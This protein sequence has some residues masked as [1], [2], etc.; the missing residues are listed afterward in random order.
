[1]KKSNQIKKRRTEDVK[2][3]DPDIENKLKY[4][5]GK[6]PK[7]PLDWENFASFE[8]PKELDIE[9]FKI[10]L[11]QWIQDAIILCKS[12][13]NSAKTPQLQVKDN[14]LAK[15]LDLDE[16]AWKK[17][18]DQY[19]NYFTNK[20]SVR[21]IE[22]FIQQP[23]KI[24]RILK[25]TLEGKIKET[26]RSKLAK[27]KDNK[28]EKRDIVEGINWKLESIKPEEFNAKLDQIIRQKTEKER[29]NTSSKELKDKIK[30]L[31][32]QTHLKNMTF[33]KKYNQEIDPVLSKKVC[34]LKTNLENEKDKAKI[35]KEIDSLTRLMQNRASLIIQG[36]NFMCAEFYKIR[37]QA[38]MLV[39][40][41]YIQILE[42]CEKNNSKKESK[43]FLPYPD[44]QFYKDA[45]S[46]VSRA[47][48]NKFNVDETKSRKQLKEAFNKYK[49]EYN[50]TDNDERFGRRDRSGPIIDMLSTA[51][52][53]SAK[54]YIE[55]SFIFKRR[56]EKFLKGENSANSDSSILKNRYDDIL[57]DYEKLKNMK[58]NKVFENEEMIQ[59]WKYHLECLQKTTAKNWKELEDDFKKVLNNKDILEQPIAKDNAAEKKKKI[60]LGVQ[61]EICEKGLFFDYLLRFYYRMMKVIE[62]E[63]N[64]A[65]SVEKPQEKGPKDYKKR[66]RKRGKARPNED[67]DIEDESGLRHGHLFALMPSFS[68]F[69]ASYIPF[70]STALRELLTGLQVV[71]D[72]RAKPDKENQDKGK[73][74]AKPVSGKGKKKDDED[75]DENEDDDDDDDDE[76]SEN[77]GKSDKKG[78][79]K[80]DKDEERTKKTGA[81][82]GKM[83]DCLNEYF[84]L[85]YSELSKIIHKKTKSKVNYNRKV[86]ADPEVSTRK[87]NFSSMATDGDSVSIIF[88][89]N[90][91]YVDKTVSVD[92]P[93]TSKNTVSENKILKV[94]EENNLSDNFLKPK[95]AARNRGSI[96]SSDAPRTSKDPVSENGRDQNCDHPNTILFSSPNVVKVS[97]I[98]NV[99]VA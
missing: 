41:M 17:I 65:K 89:C 6:L 49:K 71:N 87:W 78:K 63:R 20:Y 76:E 39:N 99:T 74:S 67:P 46:F 96:V 42:N 54:N 5:N 51:M 48:K 14:E 52:E 45:M 18:Q 12:S 56:Y 86:D 33:S 70:S 34:E 80:D 36:I 10:R 72:R 58:E 81:R 90:P 91:K 15:L 95:N 53:T 30:E 68:G 84:V 69:K 28:F 23:D 38:Y 3:I 22:D 29:K 27:I 8:N 77:K 59:Y 21:D 44:E 19:T 82:K 35:Q 32:K 24:V 9:R 7:L 64:M 62:E 4:I 79:K 88:R 60:Q 97:S 83:D 2:K 92:A 57:R 25:L 40:F 75:E 31:L 85:D 50:L 93:R 73:S 61:I 26:I 94:I 16:K 55:N 1:M 11:Q 37:I 43:E 13:W 66:K 47:D 98:P